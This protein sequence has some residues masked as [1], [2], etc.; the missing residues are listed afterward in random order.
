MEKTIS[1]LHLQVLQ[2]GE[3]LGHVVVISVPFLPRDMQCFGFNYSDAQQLFIG[4]PMLVIHVKSTG[5]TQTRVPSPG[6]LAV[7][8]ASPENTCKALALKAVD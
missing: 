5:Q 4:L 8:R 7:G 1:F 3:P 6:F 2:V